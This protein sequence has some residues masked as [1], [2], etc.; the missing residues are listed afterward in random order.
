MVAP[1]KQLTPPE[2]E[3]DVTKGVS[4]D[5][6]KAEA[7]IN[8]HSTEERLRRLQELWESDPD[9]AQQFERERSPKPVRDVP[10][11]GEAER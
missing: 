9:A 8:Q 3:A 6:D 7:Q 4:P 2:T 1:E 10:D 11:S 5:L